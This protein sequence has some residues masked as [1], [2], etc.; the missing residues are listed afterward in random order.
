MPWTLTRIN[1]RNSEYRIVPSVMLGGDHTSGAS[2]RLKVTNHKPADFT[3]GGYADG[4]NAY[5]EC[6]KRDRL[7]L[8][9]TANS[10]SP[11]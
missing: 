7:M 8:H 9:R 11:P 5:A 6:R 1:V 4:N 3:G 2:D 10:D